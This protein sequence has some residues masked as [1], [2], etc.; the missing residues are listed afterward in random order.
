MRLVTNYQEVHMF[1]HIFASVLLLLPLAAQAGNLVLNDVKA[2]NGV[3]LTVEELKQLLP[4]AKVVS[5]SKGNT[6][7]WSNKANGK[8]T[9]SSDARGQHALGKPGMTGQG[10]WH[11]GDNGTFCV[12]LEWPQHTES[13]CR[14]IFQ[15]G[16]KYY[17]V[18]SVSDG[19][20]KAYK[21]EFSK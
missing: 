15:V 19:A 10:T 21:Y 4:N 20:A 9:A 6:R 11:I 14:Y 17:G 3:Q 8:F 12:T 7:R 16:E 1:R 2:Q 18:K 5:Y 13:W